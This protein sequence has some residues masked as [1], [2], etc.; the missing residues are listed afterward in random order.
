M[1]KLRHRHLISPTG[2]E[3]KKGSV[4]LSIVVGANILNCAD[5]LPFNPRMMAFDFTFNFYSHFFIKTK[6]AGLY[7]L[8]NHF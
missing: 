4:L 5:H 8:Q 3:A 7:D 1:L 6:G 2:K